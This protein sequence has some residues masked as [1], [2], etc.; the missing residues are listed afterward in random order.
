MD[1]ITLI[2]EEAV[3]SEILEV[4]TTGVGQK[5]IFLSYE[6]ESVDEL[7]IFKG[8]SQ[9]LVKVPVDKYS[10]GTNRFTINLDSVAISTSINSS[11]SVRYKH[12]VQY[13]ILDIPHIV[14]SSVDLNNLGQ[15]KKQK[16]PLQYIARLSH[17]VVRPSYDGTGLIDN[18]Y[19]WFQ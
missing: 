8:E 15:L 18:S 1:R 19:K 13:N 10:I 2:D 4:R 3:F 5:F 7:F 14:R 16:M 9:P 6:A 11:I 17:Y 12:K